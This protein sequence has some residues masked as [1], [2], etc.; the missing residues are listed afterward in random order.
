MILSVL[1][2]EREPTAKATKT[3]TV[4]LLL[5]VALNCLL[6]HVVQIIFIKV[7]LDGVQSFFVP[8]KNEFECFYSFCQHGSCWLSVSCCCSLSP[9][10]VLCPIEK[11]CD[12]NKHC[13]LWDP[14]KKKLS[15]QELICNVRFVYCWSLLTQSLCC[16]SC[17]IKKKKNMQDVNHL[18][19]MGFKALF[20]H[21]AVFFC[22]D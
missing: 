21:I 14:E 9:V 4:S 22:T 3:L 15:S 20:L 2:R 5:F 1:G 19:E 8:Q 6:Q 10:F 17:L 11:E 16:I 13:R 18:F 12:L 7:P